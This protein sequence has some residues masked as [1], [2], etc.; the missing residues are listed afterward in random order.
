MVHAKPSGCG[1]CQPLY[2]VR[3][4]DA[5]GLIHIQRAP[6]FLSLGLKRPW[7]EGVHSQSGGD[8]KNEY[9]YISTLHIPSWIAQGQQYLYL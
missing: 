1:I 3:E 7:R 9:S 6:G 2:S 4:N 8:V 5:L